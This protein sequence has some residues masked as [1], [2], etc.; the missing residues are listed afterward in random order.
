MAAGI[1][2]FQPGTA[3]IASVTSRNF[4]LLQVKFFKVENKFRKRKDGI[5][6]LHWGLGMP[7]DR[8]NL[9]PNVFGDIKNTG[10]HLTASHVCER[11]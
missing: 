9:S 8:F 4:N 6:S 5:E 10:W 2:T 11:Q 7:I 3:A 1:G